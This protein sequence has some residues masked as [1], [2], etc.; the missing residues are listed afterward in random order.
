M[1]RRFTL[2]FALSCLIFTGLA[3]SLGG[4]EAVPTPAQPAPTSTT[5]APDAQPTAIPPTKVQIEIPTAAPTVAGEVLP[6][7]T[8][9]PSATPSP[10]PTSTVTATATRKP[11]SAT[12]TATR[13]PTNAGPLTIGYERVSIK[14]NPNNQAVLTLKVN[15]SGGGGG[16]IYYH[17]DQK[18][19]GAT[20]D[21][22]GSCGK[23]LV[24]TIKVTSADG[25]SAALPYFIA[26]ECP[27]PTPTPNP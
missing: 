7:D 20:F 3:C 25:Q 21:V 22:L 27:T 13:K 18:Q 10:T 16:Y 19:A 5:A 1:S 4:P 6:T 17:D 11:Q 14:R 8:A 26:G 15:A 2:I 24:H 9:T 12:A 23:P